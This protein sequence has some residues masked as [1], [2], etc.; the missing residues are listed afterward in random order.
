MRELIK[1]LAEEG[2]V[3]VA[4]EDV[5]WADATSMQLLERLFPLA[6]VEGTLFVLSLRP[7][8]D[9]PSSALH[10]RVTERHRARVDVLRLAAL[11]EGVDRD[12]LGA[13]I[14][15]GTLPGDV[16]R[17]VIDTAEGNP[18][19]PEE[20]V[21]SLIDAGALVDEGGRWRFRPGSSVEMPSTVER[22]IIS[23][24]D[25]LT[26]A[27][28]QAIHAASVLGRQ[29]GRELL[30]AVADGDDALSEALGELVSV[31]LL[32]EEA[33][34]EYRFQHTLIQE[35]AYQ[36][37]LKRR[38]RELHARAAEALESLLGGHLEPHFGVLAQHYRGA[39]RLR[40]ALRY[41]ELAAAEARR[42]YAVEAALDHYTAALQ[43]AE[44]VGSERMAE[45]LLRRGQVR[46]QAGQIADARIDLK[47]SLAAARQTGDRA[48]EV[49]A[50]NE[51]GF[52][53][54]GAIDY[55]EALPLLERS[56]AAAE[57]SGLHEAQVAAASRLSIV[58]TNLLRLDLAVDRAH[59]AWALAR[60]VGEDRSVA[61]A[62]DALQVASVMVGDMAT[63]DEVSRALVEIHRHRGDLWYLQFALYQ[64]A[65]VDMA[66]A[67]WDEAER[68]L[69]EAH[70]VNRRIGDRGNE[71]LFPATL[72]WVA[73]A[74][75]DLG[76]AIDLG[77]HAVDLAEE[78][79]HAEYLSWS[80]Q[81]LGWT[82]IEVFARLEAVELLER[83]LRAAQGAGG[84]IEL[85]RAACYLPLARWMAG[86]GGRALEEAA[87]AERL[88]EQITAPA[89]R[90]YLQGAD[91][92]VA[93]ATLRTLGGDPSRALELAEPALDAAAAAGWHEVEAAAALAVGRAR[94]RLDDAPEPRPALEAAVER[95]ERCGIPG[96]AWRAH[97]ELA[98][99]GLVADRSAHEARARGLIATLA[100]TIVDETI[101]RTFLEEATA[102]VSGGGTG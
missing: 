54:A 64:W 47:A 78:V 55:G 22:L 92:S 50:M 37:M 1:R 98:S 87:T 23:R 8:P 41:F 56:L 28:R 2:P 4:M 83:S 71:P 20:L 84:R 10:Q 61:M 48:L 7:D 46:A 49:E 90:A 86:D 18:L 33:P 39:G 101:S 97:A 102:E 57:E 34:S 45:L 79:G 24:I 43:I 94:A 36:N 77:R 100:G 59:R 75:G 31:D 16:E 38:R 40:E 13:L 60:E 66:A 30:E 91:G 17:R 32:L 27:A 65:W 89:G 63:V 14:G 99:V 26:P 53:L 74:R 11:P 76:R 96:L 70:A 44:S 58:Y 42:V 82:L 68:R 88:L 21:R 95:A 29:F 3:V 51:L 93:I 9:H 6:E 35:A 69:S 80:A 72:G 85:V 62:M 15:R 25:R 81:G 52:L 73:R 12:L 67:R 5:H 19:Y